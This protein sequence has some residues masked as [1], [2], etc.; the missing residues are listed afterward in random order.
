MHQI[1][2]TE[3]KTCQNLMTLKKSYDTQNN[4]HKKISKE[5]WKLE[6]KVNFI[7]IILVVRHSIMLIDEHLFHKATK[8]PWTKSKHTHGS[9]DIFLVTKYWTPFWN[10]QFESHSYFDTWT[11]K[12]L[13]ITLNRCIR[14]QCSEVVQTIMEF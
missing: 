3:I 2:T 6:N 10:P 7:I 8:L 5:K 1:M 14:K 4:D 13:K 12:T 9:H 11:S